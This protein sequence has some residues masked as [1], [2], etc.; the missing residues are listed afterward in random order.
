MKNYN[1][2]DLKLLNL[3]SNDGRIFANWSKGSR[4]LFYSAFCELRSRLLKR[5]TPHCTHVKNRGGVKGTVRWLSR[6][7][8]NFSFAAR[9]DIASY[10]NSINHSMLL[11]LFK[12]EICDDDLYDVVRSYIQFPDYRNTGKGI[13]AGGSISPLLGALYLLPLDRIMYKYASTGRIFYIRYM[14]DIIILSKTRWHLRKAISKLN[15]IISSLRLTLHPEKKFI[16]RINKGFDFLGYRF[17][18]NCKLRPS[19]TAIQRFVKHARRLCEQGA[20][21]NRLRLYV[22]RWLGYIHGGLKGLVSRKGGIKY[23]LVFILKQLDIKN[24]QNI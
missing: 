14:D 12:T 4:T 1:A 10:Y 21:W 6:R 2:T 15:G 16:G 11:D 3:W 19:K 17:K 24:I 23:Y 18:P 5:L 7:L 13:V 9:F 22:T 20:D 8:D